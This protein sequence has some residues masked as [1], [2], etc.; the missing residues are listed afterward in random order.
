MIITCR[1]SGVSVATKPFLLFE[2]IRLD[3]EKSCANLMVK[4]TE[5]QTG[6]CH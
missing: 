5:I 2:S 1:S 6:S 4:F 3:E